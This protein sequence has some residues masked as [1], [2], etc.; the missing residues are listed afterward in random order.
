MI[1]NNMRDIG[2]NGVIANGSPGSC[3]AEA[4]NIYA[5]GK[6]CLDVSATPESVIDDYSRFVADGNTSPKL[7][8]VLRFIENHSTWQSGLPEIARLPNFADVPG[9]V[10]EAIADL[11]TVMPNPDYPS[12]LPEP[13]S[14]YLER[15]RKRLEAIKGKTA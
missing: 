11:E 7:A 1:V 15:L 2:L 4:L 8:Q 12:W 5:F 9:S 10:D 14:E 6:F 13:P 3:K